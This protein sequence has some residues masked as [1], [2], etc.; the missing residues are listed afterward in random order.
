MIEIE[1]I[2]ILFEYRLFKYCE[3]LLSLFDIMVE[4]LIN[5]IIVIRYLTSMIMYMSI[6]LIYFR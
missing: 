5:K 3:L 2:M 6:G 1:L 4:D